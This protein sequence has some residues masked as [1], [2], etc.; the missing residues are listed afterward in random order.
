MVS[1]T[2]SARGMAGDHPDERPWRPT[3]AAGQAARG[4]PPSPLLGVRYV[5]AAWW[6]AFGSCLLQQWACG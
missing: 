2:M 6:I 4:R 3:N 1:I 5:M